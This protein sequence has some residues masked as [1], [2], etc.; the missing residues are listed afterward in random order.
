MDGA[1]SIEVARLAVQPGLFPIIELERGDVTAVMP[2][3][4]K[5][6]VKD[7]FAAQGRFKH[8]LKDDYRAHKELEH[9][10]A[11]ADHNIEVYGLLA[12][13]PDDWDTEGSDTVHRGGIRW[14]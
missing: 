8:L 14:A 3:R 9:L 12:D 7:Y 10:Q 11:L 6:P 13:E 5:K 2:I 4:Q 1:K